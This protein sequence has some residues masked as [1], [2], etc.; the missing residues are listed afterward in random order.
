MGLMSASLYYKASCLLG[1]GIIY[2]H[3][4]QEV[5]W[6]DILDKVLYV[7]GADE[8]SI[9]KHRMPEMIG[10]A[11]LAT[12]G[13]YVVGLQTGIFSYDSKMANLKAI[14][15]TREYPNVNLRWND[16]KCSPDGDIW[17]GTMHIDE[18]RVEQ[19]GLYLLRSS[20]EV[21]QVLDK[22]SVSN[23]ICWHKDTKRMYYICL[24]YTSPSPR[25]ATLSRMPSSA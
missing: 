2:D 3:R 12:Q 25:D 9:T 16:G 18:S 24:L 17:A 13:H 22:V 4:S 15:P 23:G 20:G 7:L 5:L 10:F 1:E 8:K 14:F 19:G 21:S 6:V 11:S